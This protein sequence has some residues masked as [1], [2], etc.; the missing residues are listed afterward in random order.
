[1]EVQNVMGETLGS[2]TSEVRK[3]NG[4]AHIFQNPAT[5]AEAGIEGGD[6]IG[7]KAAIIWDSTGTRA[8]FRANDNEVQCVGGITGQI[9]QV[10]YAVTAG[11]EEAGWLLCDGRAVSRTTYAALFAKVSTTYG[12]GDG[13]TTFNLPDTREKV[14][15]GKGTV[16][17]TLGTTYGSNTDVTVSAADHSHGVGS[18]AFNVDLDH[19]HPSF[20][21]SASAS[22]GSTATSP[23]SI[24]VKLDTHIHNVNVPALGST[25]VA[26]SGG[27]GTTAAGG[28][29]STVVSPIQ[30][31]LSVNFLIHI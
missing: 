15:G 5:A 28:A 2:E 11:S 19:D 17:P 8:L 9:I 31:T 7:G 18:L 20:N 1:M 16:F 12:V 25:P 22:S 24:S 10:A 23:G 29:F 13:S 3:A 30:K 4:Y 26:S 6:G 21:C 14:L 27:S